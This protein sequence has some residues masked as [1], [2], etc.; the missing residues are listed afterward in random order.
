VFDAHPFTVACYEPWNRL[1]GAELSPELTPQDLVAR[2]DLD[3]T[4][5]A[6]IFVVKETSVEFKAM[7]WLTKFLEHNAPSHRVQIVWSLRNYRH[8]YLSFV[9]GA[10]EWWGHTD[11]ETGADGYSQWVWRARQDTA[12]LLSLYQKYPG[13]IYAYESLVEDA[14]AT[15]PRL[16]EAIDLQF[17]DQQVDYLQHYS[18]KQVRGDVS[19]SKNPRPI[20]NES[21][22]KRELEWAKHQLELAGSDGDALR[23]QLDHFWQLVRERVVF[24]GQL[25]PELIPDRLKGLILRPSHEYREVFSSREEWEEFHRENSALTDHD[26]IKRFAASIRRTGFRYLD[27]VVPASEVEVVD[28]DYRD[29][30]V[31]EGLASHGRAVLLEFFP[32]FRGKK[33][34]PKKVRIY[35]PN[36]RSG[37][38]RLLAEYFPQLQS[39]EFLRYQERRNEFT[40]F[41]HD[42]LAA[43]TY[44]DAC[45][46]YAVVDDLFQYVPNLDAVLGEFHRVLAPGGVLFS[47]FPFA[48]S[49]EDHLI[50]ARLNADG[51]IKYL[52]EQEQQ[53]N[54]VDA[55]QPVVFQVPGWSILKQCRDLGFSRADFVLVSSPRRGI[56]ASE[57]SGVLVLRAEKSA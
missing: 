12:T 55:Q 56:L 45:F 34:G 52:V 31:H 23:E 49:S 24:A 43:L 2:F 11:M 25:P 54:G 19:M 29:S 53:R 44:E 41:E 40:D 21:M 22:E 33:I 13:A 47:T 20:S 16:M 7:Q 1:K 27:T 46:D 37:I 42:G 30:F 4:P 57:T 10:R 36:A 14:P 6:N 8:N 48:I 38:A 35:T 9:E 32:D 15:L 51:S 39:S 28:G 5:E 18:A 26:I 3:A 17:Y 50:N